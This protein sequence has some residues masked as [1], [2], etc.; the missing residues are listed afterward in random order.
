MQ[1]GVCSFF[2]CWE[3]D[4]ALAGF[5]NFSMNNLED[6][7]LKEEEKRSGEHGED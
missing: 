2:M 1:D 3:D 7:S 6:I 4:S 5:S